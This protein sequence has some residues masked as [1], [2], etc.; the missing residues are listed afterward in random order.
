MWL[1]RDLAGE[2]GDAEFL[3]DLE[4]VKLLVE[5]A[6]SVFE[7]EILSATLWTATAA[8]LGV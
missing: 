2:L 4:D 5:F 1:E 7:Q 3:D 6:A 8:A